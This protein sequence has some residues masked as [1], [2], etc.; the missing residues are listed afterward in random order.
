MLTRVER[1]NNQFRLSGLFSVLSC[2]VAVAGLFLI[3]STAAEAQTQTYS[4]AGAFARAEGFIV[5]LPV[6]G[7]EHGPLCSAL[8]WNNRP[9]G[10]GMGATIFPIPPGGPVAVNGCIPSHAQVWTVNTFA[11]TTRA[12][13]MLPTDFFEQLED[14]IPNKVLVPF[15]PNIISL[16]TDLYFHGP[17]PAP[18]IPIARQATAQ[19]TN[20]GTFAVWNQ[21]RD[22]AWTTQSSRAGLGFTWCLGNKNC[23]TIGQGTGLIRYSNSTSPTG[24]GGTMSVVLAPG[25]VAGS[26]PIIAGAGGAGGP[27]SLLIVP[28]QAP[29]LQGGGGPGDLGGKGYA[30]IQVGMAGP[31]QV[32]AAYMISAGGF[33]SALTPPTPLFPVPGTTNTSNQMPFTTGNVFARNILA[34][35]F[36]RPGTFTLSASGTDTRTSMGIGNIQL[37]AGGMRFSNGADTR[38]PNLTAMNLL[39]VPEP[40]SLGLLAAGGLF[41][42]GMTR[43]RLS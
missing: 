25:D 29:V 20:P 9:Q 7:N 13:F 5:R 2:F 15:V 40:G 26:L 14:D 4:L 42:I 43:M 23:T 37:V 18:A 39:F 17:L 32:Y 6:I 41:L 24:F 31:G 3:G 16:T 8:S 35:K 1:G 10:G 19:P 34:D 22:G 33:L 36:G 12:S 11:P 30:A 27:N 21:F 28:V 38:T